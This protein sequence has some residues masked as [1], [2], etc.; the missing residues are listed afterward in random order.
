MA[1]FD[2]ISGV[3]NPKITRDRRDTRDKKS[4]LGPKHD[5]ARDNLREVA[6]AFMCL[7][8]TIACEREA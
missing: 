7:Q 5:F 3:T 8:M 4:G 6:Y 2:Q 1:V